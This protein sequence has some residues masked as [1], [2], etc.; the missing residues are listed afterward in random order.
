MSQTKIVLYTW[1]YSLLGIVCFIL[2][3]ATLSMNTIWI[4]GIIVG[5]LFFIQG[6]R[7]FFRLSGAK[8]EQEKAFS[9][10]QRVAQFLDQEKPED[11]L[12]LANSLINYADL[13]EK[14]VLM[15]KSLRARAYFQLKR[16]TEALSDISE[17]IKSYQYK[18]SVEDY[19]L[20]ILCEAQLHLAEEANNSLKS[21]LVQYPNDPKL[22]NFLQSLSEGR[23]SVGG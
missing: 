11:A 22:L 1:G 7:N 8:Q 13:T 15:M 18:V 10:I 19:L 5:P 14:G 17:V 2:G 16:L 4:G 3:F 6:I 12:S 9:D 21:A 23:N 20:K